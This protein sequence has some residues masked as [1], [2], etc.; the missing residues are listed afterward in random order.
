M[1]AAR[2]GDSLEKMNRMERDDIVTEDLAEFVQAYL[3]SLLLY[4]PHPHNLLLPPTAP[5][6]APVLDNLYE[7]LADIVTAADT[8]HP[9][10]LSPFPS[11]GFKTTRKAVIEDINEEERAPRLDDDNPATN[12]LQTIK[13]IT[14]LT[15]QEESEHLEE[16][17]SRQ[18]FCW[19]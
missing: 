6:D 14:L 15:E 1:S 8:H 7:L 11:P 5:E 17:S 10:P 16:I 18:H 13:Q 12:L 2:N 19:G 3:K 4:N 9:E